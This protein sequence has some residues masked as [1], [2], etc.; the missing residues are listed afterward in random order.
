MLIRLY[1]IQRADA[2]HEKQLK[3]GIS[4]RKPIGP[5]AQA[6]VKWV[7]TTFNTWWASEVAV[8]LGKL[9]F[10]CYIALRNN[11]IYGFCSYNATALGFLGPIGVADENRRVGIGSALLLSCCN[12]MKMHGYGYAIVGW[13]EE[14]TCEFYRK[15]AGAIEITD[16]EP[17]IYRGMVGKTD[18]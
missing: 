5:E 2:L 13:V 17:G 6:V 9:P 1:D 12:E 10:S 11:E 18:H 14:S 4:I 16:S 15:V 3:K 8:A 7:D